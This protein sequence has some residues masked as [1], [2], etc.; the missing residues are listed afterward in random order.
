M[1]RIPPTGPPQAYQ[2]FAIHSP[3]ATHHRPATCAEAECGAH[4]NGWTSVIDEATELGQQQA[5]YIRHDA[6]R[7]HVEEKR[8]DELTEFRFEAGQ[9]CFAADSHTVPLERP[10]L[11]LVR[12]GDWRRDGRGQVRQHSGP[13]PWLDEFQTNQEAIAAR[14]NQG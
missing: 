4:L 14:I 11:Y 1:N 12:P 7:R 5:Y 6:S 13:D 8:P 3:L 9:R 2:T 10:E